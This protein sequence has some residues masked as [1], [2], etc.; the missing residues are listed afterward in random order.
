MSKTWIMKEDYISNIIEKYKDENNPM[1]TMIRDFH[2]ESWIKLGEDGLTE[3][4]GGKTKEEVLNKTLLIFSGKQIKGSPDGEQTLY[5]PDGL[6][7]S[8]C[9][10]KN[11]VLHGEDRQ[12][13]TGSEEYK[14]NWV[15]GK[16]DGLCFVS[17]IK[18]QTINEYFYINGKEVSRGEYSQ[19]KLNKTKFEPCKPYSS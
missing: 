12:Y 8:V 9:N 15:D 19:L 2:K 10:Y 1:D 17:N 18:G 11:G 5:S 14:S 7:V 6:L 16:L 3:I 13:G 4:H